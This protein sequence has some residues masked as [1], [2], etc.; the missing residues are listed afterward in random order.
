M[1]GIA[2]PDAPLRRVLVV[3]CAGA[4]KP[5]SHAGLRAKLG[6]GGCPARFD[7]AFQRYVWN[8]PRQHR[9]RIVA[10]IEQFGSHLRVIR[11]ICDSDAEHFPA[12][13][14]AS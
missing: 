12:A 6:V 9:A 13:N 14:R 2:A 10:G 11:L 1:A 7:L 3:G 4:A 5:R 8:F